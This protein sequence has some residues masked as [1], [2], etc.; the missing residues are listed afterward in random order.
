MEQSPCLYVG[1]GQGRERQNGCVESGNGQPGRSD[2]ERLGEDDAQGRLEGYDSGL[3]REGR[4]QLR[5]RRGV[6]DARRQATVRRIVSRRARPRS[7]RGRYVGYV[8][9]W[10]DGQT[11]ASSR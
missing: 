1:E 9:A 4:Q 8:R 7:G 11:L 10:I 5:Q 6:D 3:A 2:Q